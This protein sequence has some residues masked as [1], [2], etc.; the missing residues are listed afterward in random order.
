MTAQLLRE[1]GYEHTIPQF[2]QKAPLTPSTCFSL[3]I[4]LLVVTRRD[5]ATTE[6]ARGIRHV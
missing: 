6:R 1:S 2:S 3:V 5:A 4:G